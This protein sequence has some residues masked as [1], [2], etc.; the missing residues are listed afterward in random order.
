M[1]YDKDGALVRVNTFGPVMYC[2]FKSDRAGS[3]ICIY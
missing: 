2:S 1:N 3:T